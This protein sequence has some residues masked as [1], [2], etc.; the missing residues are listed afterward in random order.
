M[1]RV[2]LLL[3]LLPLLLALDP[4]AELGLSP[5]ATLPQIKRAFKDLSLK[6]HPDQNPAHKEKYQRIIQAYETLK[7]QPV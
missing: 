3:A 6:Y 1:L 7:T 5:M 4:Y 2:P